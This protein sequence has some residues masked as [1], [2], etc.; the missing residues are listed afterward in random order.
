MHLM[1][2]QLDFYLR[3]FTTTSKKPGAEVVGSLPPD[4]EEEEE[5]RGGRLIEEEDLE[6]LEY[7]DT[8]DDDDTGDLYSGLE[9]L[10]REI[11]RQKSGKLSRS[12]KSGRNKARKVVDLLRKLLMK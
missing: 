7:T 4:E 11:S 6:Y 5:D 1:D 2:H 3:T 9:K 12:A 8:D 10:R